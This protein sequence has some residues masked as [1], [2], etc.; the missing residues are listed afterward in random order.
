MKPYRSALLYL[1][2][3]CNKSSIRQNCQRNVINISNDDTFFVCAARQKII[4]ISSCFVCFILALQ[5]LLHPELQYILVCSS[6]LEE[7]A[8][9]AYIF[10]NDLIARCL[11]N[12][13]I[14]MKQPTNGTDVQR[15]SLWLDACSSK[16]STCSSTNSVKI[17]DRQPA[18][19]AWVFLPKN[20]V[21]T[22][23][24]NCWS[25]VRWHTRWSPTTQL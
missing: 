22:S 16:L 24:R 25:R 20:F 10:G 8:V 6:R 19:F 7:F 1:S 14:N 12:S 9:F 11:T 4:T 23:E 17:E 2:H 5:M 3:F 21:S 15:T 13:K 18:T